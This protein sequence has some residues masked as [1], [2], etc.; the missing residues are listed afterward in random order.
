MI[1]QHVFPFCSC[2]MAILMNV[3]NPT[4]INKMGNTAIAT[5][6][7]KKV[8]LVLDMI[9]ERAEDGAVGME[10]MVDR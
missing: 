2:A 8:D 3:Q 10:L 1:D 4:P 6:A 5:K 7:H 9:L